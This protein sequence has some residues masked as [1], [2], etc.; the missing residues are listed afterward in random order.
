[1]QRIL[2]LLGKQNAYLL[3]WF[4]TAGA[5]VFGLLYVINFVRRATVAVDIANTRTSPIYVNYAPDGSYIS[6]ESNLAIQEYIQEF[7]EPQNVEV[8]VGMNTSQ[9]WGF[10]T[11]YVAGGLQQDCS[12]CHNLENFAQEDPGGGYTEEQAARKANAKI[13]LKMV[14]DLNKN[15]ITQL[16]DIEGKNPSGAQIV[17]AT[18]HLGQAQPVSW[19]NEQHAVPDDYRLPLRDEDGNVGTVEDIDRQLVVTGRQ[20][21]SLNQV[22][23]NQYTMYHMNES[24]GVGCTHCHNSRYF[25]SWEQPAKYYAYTMLQMNQHILANYQ[26]SMGGQEPS[27]ALCHKGQVRPPGAAVS[28][29]ILPDALTPD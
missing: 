3:V 16:G 25:P 10:M 26:E 12:Y 4:G 29:E 7:P 8:L 11:A 5:M 18:C 17:C 19:E 15:W 2:D 14:A 1:M 28:A 24:L 6:P 13:H 23:Y 9:I 27:C 20:D 22:Q 21:I